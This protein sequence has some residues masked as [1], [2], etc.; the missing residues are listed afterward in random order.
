[1]PYERSYP[2]TLESLAEK[3]HSFY[4]SE[5]GGYI[6]Q[7]AQ[8]RFKYLIKILVDMT[9]IYKTYRIKNLNYTLNIYTI[10]EK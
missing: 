8:P 2:N 5:T 4:P 7:H 3:V 1:M 6:Q 10:C 9:N